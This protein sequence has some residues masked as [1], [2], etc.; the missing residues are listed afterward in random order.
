MAI[1]SLFQ[2]ISLFL[3]CSVLSILPVLYVINRYS[4]YKIFSLLLFLPYLFTMNMHSARTSVAA[5]ALLLFMVFVF[6]RNYIRAMFSFL[7]ALSFHTLSFGALFITLAL[8]PLSVLIFVLIFV[9]LLVAIY[10]PLSVFM[11]ILNAVGLGYLSVKIQGYA[12]SEAFGGAFSLYDPRSILAMLVIFLY[13]R[14]IKL[15]SQPI[16]IYLAKVYVI[17]AIVMYLFSPLV[18]ISWRVS[19]LFLLSSVIFIPNICFTFN[20]QFFYQLKIKRLMTS[21]FC[22]LYLLWVGA[23]IYN[24]Q[25]YSFILWPSPNIH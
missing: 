19:Y 2:R 16:N 24:S 1:C 4:Q 18:I 9:I 6:E 17:G 5:G 10:N 7:F 22:A 23:L 3:L 20:T 8:F 14:N 15:L 25:E 11:A 12:S 21:V 13:I